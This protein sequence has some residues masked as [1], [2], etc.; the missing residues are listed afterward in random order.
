MLLSKPDVA[1]LA[2]PAAEDANGVKNK[3]AGLNRLRSRM[4]NWFYGDNIPLPSPS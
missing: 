2:L 4:S 1:P 3:K